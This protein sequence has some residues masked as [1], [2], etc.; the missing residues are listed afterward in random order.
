MDIKPIKNE[1]DYRAA[2]AQVDALGDPTEGGEE[3]DRLD[4][5]V[6]LIEAY[7]AKHYPMSP[8]DPIAAVEYEM[9]KRGLTRQDMEDVIGP[10]GRVSEVLN[11]Q[12]PLTMTMI[13]RLHSTYDI[14]PDVLIR[15]YP[16]YRSSRGNKRIR[17]KTLVQQKKSAR[18]AA[19][20]LA[21]I[22]SEQGVVYGTRA[23]EVAA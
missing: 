13:R 3:F 4:V 21:R 19:S 16:L 17:Q 20:Q 12:R 15:E 18:E 10:S 11:R 14:R 8:L 5:L 1:D 23:S 6:T 22:D 2:L 7:E 9:E